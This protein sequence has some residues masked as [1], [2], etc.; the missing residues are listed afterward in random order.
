MRTARL[1]A[2]AYSHSIQSPYS[3]SFALSTSSLICVNRD[4]YELHVREFIYEARRMVLENLR[5][6]NITTCVKWVDFCAHWE[7]THEKDAEQFKFLYDDYSA[8]VEKLFKR[9]ADT[10]DVNLWDKCLD[11]FANDYND[12]VYRLA[13]DRLPDLERF[14]RPLEDADTSNI[15]LGVLHGVSAKHKQ[16]GA[17]HRSRIAA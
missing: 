13:I 11:S 14:L 2:Y 8:A 16:R 15:L 4:K 10:W 5:D 9:D 6:N 3:N 1:E 7:S 12:N 17:R